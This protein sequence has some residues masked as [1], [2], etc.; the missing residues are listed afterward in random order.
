MVLKQ[1]RPADLPAV[2]MIASASFKEEARR[3]EVI[4]PTFIDDVTRFPSLQLGAFEG[5]RL[6]GFALGELSDDWGLLDWIAVTPSRQRMGIGSELLREFER[7]V[8]LSGR[9][10]VRLGTAFAAG[11]YEK[12]GYTCVGSQR[13]LQ[14]VVVGEDLP[15]DQSFSIGL[16]D[17]LDM[18]E[19]FELD[20]LKCLFNPQC[21][22]VGRK[23]VGLILASENRWSREQI[24]VVFSKFET[25][26]NHFLLLSELEARAREKGAYV[27][28]EKFAQDEVDV[29]LKRGWE[30][31]RSPLSWTIY[32]MEKRL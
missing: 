7:R 1:L 27:I 16:N 4:G 2:L 10:R 9:Q 30:E 14:K 29:A 32:Y 19:E 13:A 21:F 8:L 5:G 12:M 17:V 28:T 11:F 24:D 31:P 15:Y 22:V 3:Q 20:S 18:V 25:V 23:D 26:E 6:I